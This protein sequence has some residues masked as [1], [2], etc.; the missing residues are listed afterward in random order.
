MSVKEYNYSYEDGFDPRPIESDLLT[1]EERANAEVAEV[2]AKHLNELLSQLE[3]D[4]GLVS[5]FGSPLGDV[6]VSILEPV[7]PSDIKRP[8]D[9]EQAY[10]S[11]DYS[12]DS[13][14]RL[15]VSA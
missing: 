1:I 11:L 9:H 8:E 6:E 10:T 3:A 13:G 7:N 14:M 4:V 2:F 12:R 5:V 15:P